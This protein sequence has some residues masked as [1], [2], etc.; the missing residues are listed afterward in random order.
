MTEVTP[1]SAGTVR[2][3]STGDLIRQAAEQISVLVRD[4]L[5]LARAEPAEKGKRAGLGVGMLGGAVRRVRADIDEVKGR[6]QR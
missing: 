6:A 2:D 5:A 3:Q 1:R 4:E